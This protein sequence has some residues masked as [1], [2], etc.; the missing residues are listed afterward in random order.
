[1]STH[2]PKWIGEYDPLLVGVGEYHPDEDWIGEFDKD[3]EV[4]GEY[5]P[6]QEW[7]GST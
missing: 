3:F 6:D 5:D 7:E 1:M 2:T 4:V